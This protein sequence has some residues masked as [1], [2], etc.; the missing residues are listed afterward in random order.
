MTDTAGAK[1]KIPASIL[2]CDDDALM[3]RVIGD[4]LVSSFA[5]EVAITRNAFD[6]VSNLKHGVYD[7]L[8]TDIL[9]PR[10]DGIELIIEA[11][12]L[13][14][15]PKIIA[16]SGGGAL[17]RFSNGPSFLEVAKA[18]GADWAFPRQDITTALMDL[19]MRGCLTGADNRQDGQTR[20]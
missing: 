7:A 8:V 5:C 17:G 12:K 4:T 20:S 3:G 10:M 15:P 1:S 2:I 11:K 13:A 6:A 9:L 19:A 18:L 14:F 16:Y